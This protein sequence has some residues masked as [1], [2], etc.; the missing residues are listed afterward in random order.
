MIT[1]DFKIG[2]FG[3]TFDPVHNGHLITALNVASIR[4]LDKILFIPC[5]ISPHKTEQRASS[6][7]HR[8]EMLKLA[9]QAN[10][11]FSLSDY[12]IKREGISYT[13]DTINYLKKS[14]KNIELIIGYDNFAKFATWKEPDKII[15]LVKLVVLKRSYNDI[16][17]VSGENKFFN[18]AVFVDTP[19]I[20]ISSTE[21]REHIRLNL[22]IDHLVPE[23]VMKYIID[24]KLYK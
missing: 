6:A 7:P 22:P 18:Y 16:D 21:I 3:G 5:F 12:E 11:K 10:E 24:K 14:Y 19:L 17:S 23:S 1:E 15:E 4:N 2:I 20:D 9:I 8:M 13:I